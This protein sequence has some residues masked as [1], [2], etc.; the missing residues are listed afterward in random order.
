MS[1]AFAQAVANGIMLGSLYGIVAVG[2]ALIFGVLK[3]PQ[4]A[5]G[6]HAMLGAYV[7]YVLAEQ[8]GVGYWPALVGA[9]IALAALGGL[10]HLFVFRPMSEGP[11]VNMFIAA[12][13]LLLVLQSVAVIVFGT[14]YYRIPAPIEG[15][16][17]IFGVFLTPQRLILIG[18]AALLVVGLHFFIQKTRTGACIRAVADNPKGASLVGIEVRRVGAVTM[19]I[20]SAL[21]GLGGGLI[22]PIGQI[23]PTMG[24]LLIIKAFVVVVLAGMSSIRGALVAGYALGLAESLGGMYLSLAYQDAMAFLLLLVV[25]LVRPN[26]LFSKSS[27]GGLT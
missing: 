6:A 3:I 23:Y 27:S 13:G 2:L 16:V 18:A 9:S 14:R 7:V 12:F 15:V 20:G 25:L 4:F 10:V 5:L 19:A 1:A 17:S 22:A 21:A 24:D 11:A 8:V 26:G